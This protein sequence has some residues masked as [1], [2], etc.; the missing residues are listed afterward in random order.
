[1][2]F[3]GFKKKKARNKLPTT[4]PKIVDISSKLI[5]QTADEPAQNVY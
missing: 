4:E 1:M 3:A 2:N 5:A